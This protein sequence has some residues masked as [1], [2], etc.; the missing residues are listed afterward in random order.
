MLQLKREPVEVAIDERDLLTPQDAATISARSL[1]TILS[2]M[3]LDSLPIYVLP[4]DKRKRPQRF[5]S[6]AAVEAMPKSRRKDAAPRSRA[7][8][9]KKPRG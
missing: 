2:L 5:T 3:A 4:G 1:T 9:T 8:S 7:K 6:R